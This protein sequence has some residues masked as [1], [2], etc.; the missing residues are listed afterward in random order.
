MDKDT[1]TLL[2]SLAVLVIRQFGKDEDNL[3]EAFSAYEEEASCRAEDEA[4]PAA[5]LKDAEATF[6]GVAVFQC[7]RTRVL[8]G[9]HLTMGKRIREK[10]RMAAMD[11]RSDAMR[12]AFKKGGKKLGRAVDV[13]FDAFDGD[14]DAMC[15]FIKLSA[16][17][18]E[19]EKQKGA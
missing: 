13:L 14:V 9:V 17:M 19:A 12:K 18:A 3:R 8:E 7:R 16:K 2:A 6:R 5:F 15:T 1:K 10:K 11:A 4:D